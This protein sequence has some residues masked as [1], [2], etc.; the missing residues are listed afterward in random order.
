M[1]T[2]PVL[3]SVVMV[4]LLLSQLSKTM[5]MNGIKLLAVADERFEKQMTDSAA[6]LLNSYSFSTTS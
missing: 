1:V 6:V 2:D 3:K 4:H 5:M